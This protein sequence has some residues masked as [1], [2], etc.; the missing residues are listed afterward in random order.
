MK[1]ARR[2]RP[3]NIFAATLIAYAIVPI[4]GF[5]T[6]I[7]LPSMPS[8]VSDL[9][10][11]Q[12][13]IQI[14]L[15]LFLICYGL[16][17]MFSGIL[18]DSLGRYRISLSGLFIFS[19]SSVIIA[20]ANNIIIIYA[21]RMVQ[22]I[23]VGFIVVACRAVFV[24]LYEGE[25]RKNYI[26]L[27]TV[28]WSVGPIVAPFVGGYLETLFGWRSSFYALSIYSMLLFIAQLIFCGETL[29]NPVIL[30]FRSVI[31]SYKSILSANDFISG[32][33]ILGISYALIMLFSLSSAFIIKNK[34][35]Y[36]AVMVGYASLIAG[37]AW[38][39]GGL[40][41]KALINR[42]F[43]AKI[44]NASIIQAILI[45]AMIMTA[46][47]FSNVWTFILFAFAIHTTAGFIFNNFFTYCLSRFPQMA[48]LA[49]GLTGGLAYTLTAFLS[50]GIIAMV[51]PDSQLLLGA[52]YL[53]TNIL[54][55]VVLWFSRGLF[56][57][58]GDAREL[59]EEERY[60]VTEM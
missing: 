2:L 39:S 36:S 58:K 54:A 51:K 37:L 59:P 18:L 30:T 45:V 35:G 4:S 27:M 14:T 49:G 60:L 52:A 41:G 6:D 33:L 20:V 7:Y 25:K 26:S 17:Q 34:F 32:I 28:I 44:R 46:F 3:E 43:F 13:S 47:L 9:H 42:D 57:S 15:P 5:A 56:Q 12:H 29:K 48:G 19:V 10:C 38:M 21:M 23:C 16:T 22:G 8:M 24:D 55:I 50:Y 1:S 40:I 11:S 53:V 31:K